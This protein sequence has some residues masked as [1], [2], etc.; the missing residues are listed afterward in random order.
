MET[1]NVPGVGALLELEQLNSVVTEYE[2]E[3]VH[4]DHPLVHSLPVPILQTALQ[5]TQMTST[6]EEQ[7]KIVNWRSYS[8]VQDSMGVPQLIQGQRSAIWFSPDMHMKVGRE[9]ITIVSENPAP[10]QPSMEEMQAAWHE[11]QAELHFV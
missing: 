7:P 6:E 10:H 5:S 8:L 2:L 3:D 9:N 1:L 11:F 4:M